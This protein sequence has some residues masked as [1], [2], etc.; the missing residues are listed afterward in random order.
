M[1]KQLGNFVAYL[2]IE[3]IT[4]ESAKQCLK[5]LIYGSS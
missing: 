4:I 1:N 2:P 5:D 3:N